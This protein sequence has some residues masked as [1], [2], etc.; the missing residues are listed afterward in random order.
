ME[1]RKKLLD[2]L[3]VIANECDKHET[4]DNYCPLLNE[5]GRCGITEGDENPCDWILNDPE[6]TIWRAIK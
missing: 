6:E 2:A 4:C 1:E 5:H 3:Q